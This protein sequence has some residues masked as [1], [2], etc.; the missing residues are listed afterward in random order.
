VGAGAE[1]QTLLSAQAHFK[2]QL[3]KLDLL[4]QQIYKRD[5]EEAGAEA[6]AE[7]V[8]AAEEYNSIRAEI[9][10]G[11]VIPPNEWGIEGPLLHLYP[12]IGSGRPDPLHMLRTYGKTTNYDTMWAKHIVYVGLMEKDGTL[13]APLIGKVL[14][15]DGRPQIIEGAKEKRLNMRELASL[16]G[17]YTVDGSADMGWMFEHGKT[18]VLAKL[19]GTRRQMINL[20][21]LSQGHFVDT[22]DCEARE[23]ATISSGTEILL[24]DFFQNSIFK[25][26]EPSKVGTLRKFSLV[27]RVA[28]IGIVSDGHVTFP[29][30]VE[31]SWIKIWDM[32]G[33]DRILCVKATP[34]PVNSDRCP[35]ISA[36][37]GDGEYAINAWSAPVVK[38]GV[39]SGT[40]LDKSPIHMSP[41]ALAA[42]KMDPWALDD[43]WRY[44]EEGVAAGDGSEWYPMIGSQD[45]RGQNM[46]AAVRDKLKGAVDKGKPITQDMVDQTFKS[47]MDE[48]DKGS[49]EYEEF[50]KYARG[51]SV[52]FC[53]GK[54][55]TSMG[56]MVGVS[57]KLCSCTGVG[58]GVPVE[59]EEPC[60]RRCSICR[61]GTAEASAHWF[62]SN[63]KGDGDGRCRACSEADLSSG[64]DVEIVAVT[65]LRGLAGGGQL[66]HDHWS[67]N[68]SQHDPVPNGNWLTAWEKCS[69]L[70]YNFLEKSHNSHK[71]R[72]RRK[73]G[74]EN[75]QR[76]S[77]RG[78]SHFTD[79][80]KAQ[81]SKAAKVLTAMG[82]ILAK[83]AAAAVVKH[84]MK[85]RIT[86]WWSGPSTD[87][88]VGGGG[89]RRRTRNKKRQTMRPKSRKKRR[90]Q[91]R[92]RPRSRPRR[93]SG[94][95]R[96]T[97]RKARRTGRK[98]R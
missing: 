92:S 55:F 26:Q 37:N 19:I 27:A 59:G 68:S 97:G 2:G 43:I 4:A 63:C 11:V 23:P 67:A 54:D 16:S 70:G 31:E 69:N 71:G 65:K 83:T 24:T 33:N 86:D 36:K 94:K 28:S 52:C 20:Y 5:E 72:G 76:G 8:K 77:E 73:W 81:E 40:T 3:E 50:R 38:G 88:V 15:D 74:C 30:P 14:L 1:T 82:I 46:L 49:M 10:R 42:V 91:T 66:G 34:P 6:E 13:T 75:M 41:K 62:C 80:E 89:R 56:R 21:A 57:R 18:G 98:S 85:G 51:G 96:R 90:A 44:S 60:E 39:G 61:G 35:L 9:S 95:A 87:A 93:A 48:G 64:G 53:C 7:A 84:G 45:P 58:H 22:K 47:M 79:I 32:T 29:A 12:A 17:R 25:E 78:Y